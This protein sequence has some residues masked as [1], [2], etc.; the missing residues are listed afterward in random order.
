MSYRINEIFYSLQG[1]GRHAGTPAVFIRFAGCNLKCPFCD[2]DWTKGYA[3]TAAE[4]VECT[5]MYTKA[6]SPKLVVL[7]GGEP[8]L[9]VDSE[10]LDRLHTK[11]QTIAIETNGT[12][13][14]PAGVDFVTLSPKDDFV[15]QALSMLGIA[16]EVK[17]VYDANHNPEFWHSHIVAKYYYLQP[18]DTGSEAKNREIIEK[19]VRYIKAHPWWKLSL[20]TQKILNIK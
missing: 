15:P 4:I 16:D 11:F 9:Q 1:E 6:Y 18:C 7:T 8:T 19:C 13:E 12:H 3:M 20:Q 17:V 2:T 14:V 5:Q 10:L